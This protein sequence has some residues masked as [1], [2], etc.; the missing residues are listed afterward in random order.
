MAL[1]E[2]IRTAYDI[3]CGARDETKECPNIIVS[4]ENRHVQKEGYTPG[5]EQGTWRA[6][7]RAFRSLENIGI[8]IAT[9]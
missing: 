4:V 1:R 7:A 6:G 3:E 8:L 5:L 9:L 2:L